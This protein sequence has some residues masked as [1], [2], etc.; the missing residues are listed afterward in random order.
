[1]PLPHAYR[2][3][4]YDPADRAPNGTYEGAQDTDSDHGPVEAAYLAAVAAFAEESGVERL[5]VRDP[6][7]TGFVHFGREPALEGH[8]LAGLFPDG[9]TGFH[10]GAPVAVPLALELVRGMLRDHGLWCRLEAEGVFAVHVGWDQ[11]VYVAT[12]TPCEAAV[13]RTHELGIFAEPIEVSPYD[14]SL[15][16]EYE[17]RP[18]DDGFWERVR[19]SAARGEAGL[20][21]ENPVSNLSRWHRVGDGGRLDAVRAGLGPRA[22]LNVWPGLSTD[23]AG[24]LAGLPEEFTLECV[25]EDADGRITSVAVDEDDRAELAEVLAGARAA[26]LLAVDADEWKP[27]FTGVVPDADGVVRARWRL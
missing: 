17:L 8:G 18:A 1:M 6:Q 15:D 14:P 12:R 4:K 24:L 20:I 26:A 21:E 10:D 5:T 25:W 2:V 19:E 13:A 27:L 23:T 22:L 11:Y 3:T 7:V 16:E 9:L